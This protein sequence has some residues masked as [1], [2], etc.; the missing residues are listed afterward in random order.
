[1]TVRERRTCSITL[2]SIQFV[3][4]RFI[5]YE[6]T[7]IWWPSVCWVTVNTVNHLRSNMTLTQM[8]YYTSAASSGC[9]EIQTLSRNRGF[10][11]R[12]G[13]PA[14]VNQTYKNEGTIGALFLGNVKN[15]N[16]QPKSCSHSF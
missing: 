7:G 14:H 13:H 10:Q 15:S 8:F 5:K 12:Y 4:V 2:F 1:M 16:I 11:A 9:L 3:S 6:M